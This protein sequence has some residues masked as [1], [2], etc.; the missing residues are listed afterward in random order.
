[1]DQKQTI[2]PFERLLFIFL[3][4]LLLVGLILSYTSEYVYERMVMEDGWI[5]NLTVV[6]LL[7]CSFIS[8]YRLFKWGKGKGNIWKLITLFLA[9][10]FLFGAGE[11]LSWGQRIFDIE[12]GEFFMDKN[13]QGETNLHN[14]EIKG[15]KLNRLIFTNLLGLG[16][17]IYFLLIKPLYNRFPRF[18]YLVNLWGIPIPTL[19]QSLLML[20]STGLVLAMDDSRKWEVFEFAFVM[21]LFVVLLYPWNKRS[22]YSKNMQLDGQA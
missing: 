5:E 8:F 19:Y 10:G 18:K 11:E 17:I 12:S 13:L 14:L 16:A 2:K 1:M 7:T 3:L 4:I 15:V 9:I 20:I 22:I 6:V 21:V